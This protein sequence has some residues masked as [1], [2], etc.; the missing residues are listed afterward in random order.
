MFIV[1][2]HWGNTNQNHSEIPLHTH[3]D[4][5]Y[6][7]KKK[8]GEEEG[9]GCSSCREG[10]F[11]LFSGYHRLP[12]HQVCP[13][14][15]STLR[16][17]STSFQTVHLGIKKIHGK[18]TA[19]GLMGFGCW[20]NGSRYYEHMTFVHGSASQA[21]PALGLPTLPCPIPHGVGH[22]VGPH[23]S[24]HAETLQG[25]LVLPLL[26]KLLLLRTFRFHKLFPA[27]GRSLNVPIQITE[28]FH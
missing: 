2:S 9:E 7:K 15:F 4:G 20:Y 1:I 11:H 5:Y 28:S 14:S 24:H 3:R 12:P 16:S 10:S 18:H 8:K 6:Q 17:M 27:L 19:I 22:P 26:W 25:C 13:A 21:M 23:G